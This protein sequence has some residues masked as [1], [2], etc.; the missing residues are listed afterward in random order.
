MVPAVSY[1]ISRVPYYSGSCRPSVGSRIRDFH[2]LRYIFPDISTSFCL[3]TVAVLLPRQCRNIAGLGS[4]A[5]ARHYLR[6]HCYFLFLWVLRCFS[7][8]RSLT[9]S[10]VCRRLADGLPH[11][12]IRGS[13]D[14]CSS[15][16][17]FAAYHV[18]LRL[19]EPR[20]PPFALAYFLLPSVLY[21]IPKVQ[22]QGMRY[23][24][25]LLVVLFF[26]LVFSVCQ[27]A[28]ALRRLWRITDSN[29]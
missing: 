10:K 23:T 7:S 20:H 29:R 12:D 19:R 8:P 16:R 15:P 18:L 5:F 6:N 25:L 28:I 9:L 11:S 22:N 24:L 14:I 4:S 3:D 13:R 1:R 21:S 17:L 26:S 2:P 27:I